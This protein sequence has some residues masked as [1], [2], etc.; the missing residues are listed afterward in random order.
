MTNIMT[1]SLY[2]TL[3]PKMMKKDESVIRIIINN[4]KF[5]YLLLIIC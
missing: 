5:N 3:N 4:H 1:I 2:V